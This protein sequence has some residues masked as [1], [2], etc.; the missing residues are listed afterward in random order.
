MSVEN[1]YKLQLI[2][3]HAARFIKQV[4][5]TAKVTPLLHELHWLP[6]KKRIFYKIATTTFNFACMIFMHQHI[7]KTSFRC[8]PHHGHFA[9]VATVSLLRQRKVKNVW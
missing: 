4:P 1:I 2:Q 5:K 8:M 7:F 9:L 3:N 6:V